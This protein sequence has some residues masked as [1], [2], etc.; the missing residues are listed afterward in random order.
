LKIK[1]E[2]RQGKIFHGA[3]LANGKSTMTVQSADQSPREALIAEGEAADQ[4]ISLA[5]S[6]ESTSSNESPAETPESAL[7]LLD[8]HHL[9]MSFE[10]G[11]AWLE[12]HATTINALNVFPV[13]DGDTGTNML[14]TL[15]SAIRQSA[16]RTS[17]DA[18]EITKHLALGAIQGARGNSGVILS[19]ILNGF[20]RAGEGKTSYTSHD[21]ARCLRR[22]CDSAYNAVLKPVEGTILTVIRAI[23]E[24]A[25]EA[26]IETTDI[27]EFLS[28]IT[29]A[30]HQALQRTPEL[31][32][33]LKEA[34]VVDSGGQ[35]LVTIF[36]GMSRYLWGE[37]IG[38]L[39]GEGDLSGG[40]AAVAA[41]FDLHLE[42]P[43][44]TLADGKYGYDIQY[45][46][47]GVDLD[48]EA[49]HLHISQLGD[50]PLV[51]GTSELIKV[52]VHALSPIPA[53]EYGLSLGALDDIVIENMDL[54]FQAFAEK[55]S[56][57]PKSALSLESLTG[58]GI[59]TVTAG[60]GLANHFRELGASAVVQG[61]QGM[62][63][64][65]GDLL[66][67]VNAINAEA[68]ILLPN[69]KNVIMAAEQAAVLAERPVYVVPSRT[70]PQGFAALMAF[71]YSQDA[72]ANASIMAE[73]MHNVITV[74]VT[75]AART[76]NVNN[77]S[78][79][80]GQYIGLMD[81]QLISK[82]D[83]DLEVISDVFSRI[84]LAA[85]E[86]VS[87]F[88]GEERSEEEAEGLMAELETLHPELE[89][90]LH[91]GQ[92]PHYSFILSI[93]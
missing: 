62:N 75:K 9:Q 28:R 6:S 32:P 22:A 49:A 39:Q 5:D 87:L 90:E 12:R 20:A 41:K 44:A 8:G 60:E 65:T 45:L 59:V 38:A 13:P 58:I 15:R 2:Q 37:K 18:A 33:I 91:A 86:I 61:G 66:D 36:E 56:S 14:M 46:I 25:E 74:E 4:A 16:E 48:V 52:H 64:S 24:A 93:E 27:R 68:V 51:V 30:A 31:L 42:N 69:N 73:A 43:P 3:I 35:G 70:M 89:Y 26:A 78:I 7:Y 88:Y 23:A 67:A 77:L 50:C 55:H 53:L 81:G 19:Q 83:N 57:P 82:G 76:T 10:S 21:L 54:Q 34:G 29:T 1:L 11:L 85:Y 63:P 92:Q 40:P 47:R 84:D 71:N 80:E 17:R 72:E 79:Q